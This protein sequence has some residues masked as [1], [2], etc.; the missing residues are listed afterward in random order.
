RSSLSLADRI[1]VVDKGAVADQ[2]THEELWERC[3]LYRLLL[4]GPGGDAE[5]L[6]AIEEPAANG[7]GH[8][9]DGIT[10]SAWRGPDAEE[11]GEAGSANRARLSS[12]AGAVRV[13][14]GG[15]AVGGGANWGAALAPTP[16][17]LAQVDALEPATSDPQV[18]VAIESAPAPNFSF[19]HFLR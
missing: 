1:V 7:D 3:S 10:P 12:P 16:E 18:D 19:L 5:G 17:L 8:R 15:G 2:G 14:G 13:Q 11:V 9:V 4:S 6:E